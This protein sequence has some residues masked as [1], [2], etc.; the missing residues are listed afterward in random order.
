MTIKADIY[1]AIFWSNMVLD[2]Q[3]ISTI[4]PLQV[5]M[6]PSFE[7]RLRSTQ[8]V[9]IGS[10]MSTAILYWTPY[11]RLLLCCACITDIPRSRV[12]L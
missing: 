7:T 3:N 9:F 2:F 4:F 10:E 5:S 12:R 11:R 6:A 8:D 1:V